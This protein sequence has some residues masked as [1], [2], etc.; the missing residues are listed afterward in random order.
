M[1]SVG[2]TIENPVNGEAI[3]WVETAESSAGE[4]LAFDL[5]LRPGAS[6]AATHRH[7]RQEERFEVRAGTIGLEVAGAERTLGVGEEATIPAG[8]AH[9]WWNAGGGEALVR[10]EL[11]PALD[12]ETFFEVLF[13]LARDGRTNRKG[14]PGLLQIAVTVRALV[15]SCSTLVTPPPAVQRAVFALLAP[16]GRRRGLRPTYAQYS[17]DHPSL[18]QD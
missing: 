5:A 12:T 4:L 9:R 2:E 15:D 7:V 1:A 13:G 18:S 3:T 8:V 14:I 11:R 17:P 10:V 16:I 6:V